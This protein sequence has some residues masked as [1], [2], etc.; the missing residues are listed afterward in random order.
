MDRVALVSAPAEIPGYKNAENLGLQYIRAAIEASGRTVELFEL[1]RIGAAKGELERL[2]RAE[3]F[4]AIGLGVLFT[5]HLEPTIELAKRLRELDR[6]ALI[7][8]G[9]QGTSFVWKEVLDACRAIDVAVRFEGDE[10]AVEVLDAYSERRPLSE[11]AGIYYRHGNEIL[12][13]GDRSPPVN[14]DILPF[15]A[16]DPESRVLGAGHFMVLTSRGCSARCTFCGSGNF[17]NRYHN[18]TRW[19]SRSPENI[20]EEIEQLVDIHGCTAVSFVDDD[21]FGACPEGIE[22]GWRFA[23]EL[24]RKNLDIRW[25]IECRVDEIDRSLLRA[26][27]DVGLRHLLIGIDAGNARDLKLYGKRATTAQ[28]ESAVQILREEGLSFETGFIMYHPL[29]EISNLKE[30]SS[31]LRKI[32]V[33]SRRMLLNKLE[34]Y[35]GSPLV[36]YFNRSVGLTKTK[37]MYGYEFANADVQRIRR[38][39]TATT[40]PFREVDELIERAEFAIENTSAANLK[41]RSEETRALVRAKR[42]IVDDLLDLF[43]ACIESRG[44][45]P[46]D[47]LVSERKAARYATELRRVISQI[48]T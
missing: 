21:F 12:S 34:I 45:R 43:D 40:E 5:R 36:A 23:A 37:F 6:N 47:V 31:F 15:P 2:V 30:N 29:S 41:G 11:V 7:M 19:R 46:H 18:E 24:A 14:L 48:Q 4:S 3:T 28:I 22:R 38:S 1:H 20:V 17:G 27:R 25:S 9:G 39:M 33:A 8:I 35:A 32:G 10:T 26:L 44:N 13:T 42:M 16:R